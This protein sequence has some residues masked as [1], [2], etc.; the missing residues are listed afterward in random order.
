M[1]RILYGFIDYFS[2]EK[3]EAVRRIPIRTFCEPW[4]LGEADS[5]LSCLL[6][7]LFGYFFGFFCESADDADVTVVNNDF[8]FRRP[9]SPPSSLTQPKPGI[10][11]DLTPSMTVIVPG[12]G[13]GEDCADALGV[14]DDVDAISDAGSAGNTGSVSFSAVISVSSGLLSVTER[15]IFDVSVGRASI[16]AVTAVFIAQR[17]NPRPRRSEAIQ[18][19][20][21]RHRRLCPFL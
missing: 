13:S 9:L 15:K 7:P 16:S 10:H 6:L 3:G 12:F 2:K 20:T 4:V 18:R 11:M 8:L 19:Y 21:M 5:R 17:V 14:A 1:G